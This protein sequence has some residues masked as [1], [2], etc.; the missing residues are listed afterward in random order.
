MAFLDIFRTFDGIPL[1]AFLASSASI[2]LE[3]SNGLTWVN[4]NEK[5]GT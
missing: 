4:P 3:T 1:D 2:C 5:Q